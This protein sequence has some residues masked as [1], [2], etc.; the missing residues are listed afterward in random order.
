M[1][2]QLGSTTGRKGSLAGR[3]LQLTWLLGWMSAS[4]EAEVGPPDDRPAFQHPKEAPPSPEQPEPSQEETVLSG[5]PR[6]GC[7]RVQKEKLGVRHRSRVTTVKHT[8]GTMQAWAP[9]GHKPSGDGGRAQRAKRR[10][11]MVAQRAA[12]AAQDAEQSAA[13]RSGSRDLA[14]SSGLDGSQGAAWGLATMLQV[15]AVPHSLLLS[16]ILIT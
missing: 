5:Q 13:G 11:L 7:G 6:H 10:V 8:A 16:S 15:S 12:W 1:A 14:G 2:F 3:P 4:D 9:A